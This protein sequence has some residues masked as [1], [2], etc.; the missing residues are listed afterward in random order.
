V[1]DEWERA[2]REAASCMRVVV[3]RTGVVLSPRRGALARML[4]FFRAGLGGP[5]AGEQHVPWVHLDDVVGAV[6]QSID[7]PEADGPVNVNVPQAVT[8]RE[9]SHTLGRVLRRPALLPV[10][11]FALRALYGEMASIVV[12]GQRVVPRRLHQLGY[13][14]RQPHLEPALRNLVDTA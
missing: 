3:M 6:L 10:P 2:A 5:V 7:D 11:A 4:P 9:L 1:V 13:V 14:V 8:N 12:T